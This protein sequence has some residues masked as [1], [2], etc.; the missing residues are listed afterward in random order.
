MLFSR[1]SRN[2]CLNYG[3]V[4]TEQVKSKH[5][6]IG[7][8]MR[9]EED[10]RLAGHRGSVPVLA[11]SKEGS[12]ALGRLLGG[13]RGPNLPRALPPSLDMGQHWTNGVEVSYQGCESGSQAE[14]E[15]PATVN[16]MHSGAVVTDLKYVPRAVPGM[17]AEAWLA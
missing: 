11:K 10:R 13:R 4:A 17:R 7:N 3:R 15:N 5:E 6:Q 14:G 16:R 12:R 1:I 2:V 9:G 8:E